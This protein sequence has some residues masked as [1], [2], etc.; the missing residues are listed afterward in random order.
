MQS[1]PPPP[2]N[3]IPTLIS[4]INNIIRPTPRTLT[5]RPSPLPISSHIVKHSSHHPHTLPPLPPTHNT[6]AVN[7]TYRMVCPVETVTPRVRPT[8]A[9]L[10]HL[11]LSPPSSPP[12][13][14]SDEPPPPPPVVTAAHA[15]S[16][17]AAVAIQDGERLDERT[18]TELRGLRT[19]TG[20]VSQAGGSA[21][22]EVGGTKVI[23]AVY[24]PKPNPKPAF[25][26][27]AAV[28]VS[29]SS[30]PF[31]PAGQRGSYVPSDD[32]ATL[33]LHVQAALTAAVRREVYPKSL[34]E[35]RLLLVEADGSVPAAAVCAAS[36]ALA[37]AGIELYDLAAGAEVVQIGNA[38]VVDPT[39]A[40]Q[41]AAR[42]S[43]S[44][45]YLPL[46]DEI[47]HFALNGQFDPAQ[48]A[49]ATQLALDA[50]AK[51]A[52]LL[53]SALKPEPQP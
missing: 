38:L 10:A 46:L 1:S 44:L 35:V 8:P 16:V 18:F 17:D 23:A 31:A 2:T 33:G 4:T 21:Y 34:L 13:P 39:A 7:D 37:H 11:G 32:D 36:L 42:G 29:V 52:Q 48:L 5:P 40:E 49:D 22:V 41:N 53:R 9:Q 20:L 51:S 30:A 43:V 27:A 28:E 12:S 26:A 24:G 50:A 47:S 45:A 6:M 3:P 15:L 14:S 25:A 19:T